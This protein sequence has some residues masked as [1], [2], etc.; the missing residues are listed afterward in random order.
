MSLSVETFALLKKTISKTVSSLSGGI[1][2]RGTLASVESLPT[3]AAAGDLYLIGPSGEGSDRYAEYLY[4]KD[5]Q[6][7]YIGRLQTDVDLSSYATI[8][9]LNESLKS[10]AKKSEL[11]SYATKTDL[12]NKLDASVYDDITTA[13]EGKADASEIDTIKEEIASLK[14]T[15]L[16]IK[17]NYKQLL[18]IID[19]GEA[20]DYFSIGDQIEVVWRDVSANRDYT[21]PLDIVKFE[22]VELEDGRTV[23]GM[24]VQFHYAFPYNVTYDTYEAFYVVPEG[25]LAPG[26]YNI[27]FDCNYGWAKAGKSY[28]FILTKRVEAG[29]QLA[30]FTQASS[31]TATLEAAR[32]YS[33]ANNTTRTALETVLVSEVIDPDAD[34]GTNLGH[35]SLAGNNTIN[36]IQ[37]VAW[38]YNNWESSNIR[39]WLNSNATA[40]NWYVHPG[41]KNP[42]DRPCA[43]VNKPGFLTGFDD[44]F[45]KAIAKIKVVTAN[46]TVSDANKGT[47]TVTYDKVFLPSLSEMYINPQISGNAEQPNGEGTPFPYW[48]MVKSASPESKYAQWGTYSELRGF[49]LENKLSPQT[50]R[51][52]SAFR[53]NSNGTWYVG[54]GGYVGSNY[55]CYAARGLPAMCLA[56]T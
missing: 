55:A 56:K 31:D 15:K 44:D 40:N 18:D 10:Y 2:L 30:G 46:S 50:V 1:M 52:R 27:T 26:T 11:S 9:A 41:D 25:G 37:R 13:L 51:L 4:T 6:W 22:D 39:Q 54:S 12:S 33:Y 32:V 36:S 48:K 45:K 21:V 5:N 8:D 34:N 20:E 38:G 3:K 17:M 49:G 42:F 7:E 53:G 35:F 43:E 19:A 23:P 24:F 47:W 29:G 14:S 28:K 16:D